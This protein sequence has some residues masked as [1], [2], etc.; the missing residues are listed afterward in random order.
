MPTKPVMPLRCLLVSL[1]LGLAL[2]ALFVALW[3]LLWWLL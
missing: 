3:A 2:W 1:P